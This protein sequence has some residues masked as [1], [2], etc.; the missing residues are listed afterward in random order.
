MSAAGRKFLTTINWPVINSV[1]SK[2]TEITASLGAFRKGYEE[3]ERQLSQLK[4]SDRSVDFES[5]RRILKN[6][7]IIDKLEKI[8][9]TQKIVK[10][11]LADQLK[12]ISAFEAK[13]VTSAELYVK[14]TEANLA[15][16][17]ETVKNIDQAR[18]IT[19][20]TVDDVVK[21]KPEIVQRTEDL[22]KQGKFTVDGYD[23]RF[24]SL[25]LL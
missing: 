15:D 14:E 16:L 6:S 1:L 5:Y 22:V 23:E 19:Q 21:A 2:H 10:V 9:N 13:A 7:D 25:A 12:T 18:P 8:A 17:S 20:L 24:P 4:E 11:D 3:A